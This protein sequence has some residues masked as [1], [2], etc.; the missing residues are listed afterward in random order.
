[1]AH[2]VLRSRFLHRRARRIGSK[3]AASILAEISALGIV[4]SRRRVRT[5]ERWAFAFMLVGIIR[6]SAAAAFIVYGFGPGN[7]I[8]R[9]W[10]E[11]GRRFDELKDGMVR[12]VAGVSVLEWYNSVT[13]LLVLVL[14]VLA[15]FYGFRPF[16]VLNSML[17]S[18]SKEAELHRGSLY[19]LERRSRRALML[20]GHA[21]KCG[22]ALLASGWVRESMANSLCSMPH[23]E[24]AVLR[25]WKVSR[26]ARERIRRHHKAELKRHAGRV[27]SV[28]RAAAMRID[29][30]PENGL[31]DLGILLVRIGDGIAEGRVGALLDEGE[32]Q[33]HEPVRDREMLRTVVASL[34]IAGAAVGIS[35]LG[36]PAEIAGTLTTVAGIAVLVTLFRGAA[37]GVETVALL[38]GPK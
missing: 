11:S 17:G 23:I 15:A 30:D 33:D 7:A 31:R 5:A 18:R 4:Q 26:P 21:A 28:L 19:I 36:L 16:V 13:G 20:Y 38:L 12:R 14:F 22:R 6:L 35:L 2:P 9:E 25:S 24:R 32:L 8:F 1:M 37:K 29:V 27:V 10:F 3:Y 34:L